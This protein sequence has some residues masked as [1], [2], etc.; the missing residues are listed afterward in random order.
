MTL[1]IAPIGRTMILLGL[2]VAVTAWLSSRVDFDLAWLG[3]AFAAFAAYFFRDPDREIAE[4]PKAALSP[5]AG[6]VMSIEKDGQE[7]LTTVRIFLAIWNVHVQRAPLAGAVKKITYIPGAF[8]VAK[9]PE[10]VQNERNVIRLEG[11]SG[12]AVVEQIAGLIAR[13]IACYVREGEEV[14]QGQRVG[15]I[16]FGSQCA[17]RLPAGWEIQ[18]RPGQPVVGG[19]SVIARRP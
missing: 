11:S 19:I 13:R 6:V 16:Y 2:A 1:K 8:A 4:D 12:P 10:A 18:V 9:A 14:R 17:L 7:G 5:A 3:L 15:I